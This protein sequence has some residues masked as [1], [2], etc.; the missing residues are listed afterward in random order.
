[1]EGDESVGR[2]SAALAGGVLDDGVPPRFSS[3]VELTT[4]VLGE[5]CLCTGTLISPYQVLTSA[6]C[7][8]NS[9][10]A[11][12]VVKF[13]LHPTDFGSTCIPPYCPPPDA[14]NEGEVAVARCQIHPEMW[15]EVGGPFDCFTMGGD[16]YTSVDQHFSSDHDVAVLTL[17]QPIL[18]T[19]TTAPPA[20]VHPSARDPHRLL[21]LGEVPDTGWVG[22]PVSLVGYGTTVA[23]SAPTAFR[24]A[25][26]RRFMD[27][28]IT[29]IAGT[30]WSSS[31]VFVTGAPYRGARAGDSG[32]PIIWGA[33]PSAD[34][35][36][37]AVLGTD[38]YFPYTRL[39]SLDGEES[40]LAWVRSVLDPDGDGHGV[41][42]PYY[43]AWSTDYSP[44]TDVDGD[45]IDE[46]DDNCPGVFNILQTDTDGDGFGDECDS[47]ILGSNVD[48]DG[49]G[50]GDGCD[51]CVHVS[52][53]DQSDVDLDLLGDLCDDCPSISDLAQSNCNADAEEVAGLRAV[54]DA[55]DPQ[56]CPETHP[57]ASSHTH[58]FRSEVITDQLAV[59]GLGSVV[60][61][62]RG[63]HRWCT[64][65]AA[66][67][68]TAAVRSTCRDSQMDFTGSCIEGDPFPYR[69]ID[70]TI[71]RHWQ[72]PHTNPR[73]YGG[74]AVTP[75]GGLPDEFIIPYDVNADVYEF[76]GVLGYRHLFTDDTRVGW[77]STLDAEMYGLPVVPGSPTL[78]LRG[79]LW[80]HTAGPPW[81]ADGY[82]DTRYPSESDR[83][84][85]LARLTS[86]YWAGAIAPPFLVIAPLPAQWPVLPLLVPRPG[87]RLAGS[88]VGNAW[89]MKI[90]DG[91]CSGASCNTRDLLPF[92]DNHLFAE[93][94]EVAPGVGI[95][96]DLWSVDGKWLAA[97]EPAQWLPATR[98]LYAAFDPAREILTRALDVDASG[99]LQ[100][101]QAQPPPCDDPQLGCKTTAAQARPTGVAVSPLDAVRTDPLLVLSARKNTLYYGGGITADGRYPGDLLAYDLRTGRARPLA[102]EDNLRLGRVLGATYS[103]ADDALYVLDVPE[104]E[105]ESRRHER[106]RRE[107][108][109]PSVRFLRIAEGGAQID[110]LRELPHLLGSSRFA[111][112]PAPDGTLY[113]VASNEAVHVVV[114]L[115]VRGD[116]VRALGFATGRGALAPGQ[117]RAHEAGVTVLTVDRRD[118][119]FAIEY[120]A[121]SFSAATRGWER[122]C[123]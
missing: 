74:S 76:G 34:W 6:H 30:V 59:D 113:L 35:R 81:P 69:S 77:N 3:V 18:P 90:K 61:Y 100:V 80:A 65:S 47:C 40:N 112:A 41:A 22:Q 2:T 5:G 29:G 72:I 39:F 42:P 122:R 115:Q 89:L 108:H 51:N 116:D 75:L 15:A 97:S 43:P 57:R 49:D 96:S 99:M 92:A 48:S 4:G 21:D 10:C 93:P 25:G 106:S 24:E 104:P 105:H 12:A 28:A 95:G 23:R 114:R 38:V 16:Y 33:D 88:F 98:V 109:A 36:G 67:D 55:C 119:P 20:F 58:G 44:T 14:S 85:P 19:W 32:G 102:L 83:F 70:P 63:S 68:N 53:A 84:D 62:A 52:N 8:I 111:L 27:A 121:A 56:P 78:Q 54:G 103:P 11:H 26:F 1:M 118:Q 82:Y 71:R 64:C 110:V 73:A 120:G 45:L 66:T 87:Y 7:V 13:G 94:L 101:V 60:R 50:L 46:V 86:N 31:L 91:A 37:P 107:E 17:Q 79:V 123:F 9:V 117:A